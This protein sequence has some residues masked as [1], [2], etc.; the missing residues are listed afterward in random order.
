[1]TIIRDPTTVGY[2]SNPWVRN[3]M[4]TCLVSSASTG[5]REKGRPDLNARIRY[6]D[7]RRYDYDLLFVAKSNNVFSTIPI[8]GT[9]TRNQAK[10]N[11]V[12]I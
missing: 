2:L 1:M 10:Y 7:G 9:I 12:L 6:R 4:V 3:R 11:A 8:P 5:N